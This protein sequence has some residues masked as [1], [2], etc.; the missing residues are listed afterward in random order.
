MSNLNEYLVQKLSD[1]MFS[2]KPLTLTCI[3][4]Y[5]LINLVKISTMNKYSKTI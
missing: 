5:N 2:M 1:I 3:T 4:Q